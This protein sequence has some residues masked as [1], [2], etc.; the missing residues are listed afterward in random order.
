MSVVSSYYM[1]T[2]FGAS[3]SEPHI[4]ELNV[5]N[6]YIIMFFV[7]YV[8]HPRAAIV[9]TLAC[10]IYSNWPHENILVVSEIV[11]LCIAIRFILMLSV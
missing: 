8:R 11:V 10:A 7:W 2:L 4:D 3:L 9:I 1:Y 5:R 6:P